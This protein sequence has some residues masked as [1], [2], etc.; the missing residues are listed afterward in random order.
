MVLLFAMDYVFSKLSVLL[1]EYRRPS[2]ENERVKKKLISSL[3]QLKLFLC[4]WLSGSFRH[5]DEKHLLKTETTNSSSH[6]SKNQATAF[7]GRQPTKRPGLHTSLHHCRRWWGLHS[8]PFCFPSPETLRW[9]INSVE[10]QRGEGLMLLDEA[11]WVNLSTWWTFCGPGSCSPADFSLR[12]PHGGVFRQ[13]T[14]NR[15]FLSDQ[16]GQPA[17]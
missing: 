3:L 4:R 5:T 9:T 2:L 15:Q 13:V 16:R 6:C 17:E 1:N 8:F 10:F 7:K 14:R 11:D 12:G